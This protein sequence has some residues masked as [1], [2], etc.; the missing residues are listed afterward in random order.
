MAAA[1]CQLQQQTVLWEGALELPRYGEGTA[2]ARFAQPVLVTGVRATAGS[3]D[4]GLQLPQLV[5][6]H[7]RDLHTPT[8][9]RFDL[10]FNAV[11]VPQREMQEWRVDQVGCHRPSHQ[12]AH[13]SILIWPRNSKAASPAA[14]HQQ[15]A[16]VMWPQLA[17]VLMR[18][19]SAVNVQV[20]PTQ[21]VWLRGRCRSIT[22][23]LLGFALDDAPQQIKVGAL[24]WG[25]HSAD[26]F[27]C[28]GSVLACGG[29][30][31]T[32]VVLTA[33]VPCPAGSG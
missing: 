21:H 15:A 28:W 11:A 7:A 13:M 22:V 23:Q 24:C 19:I 17:R 14:A 32:V 10:L 30:A 9:A 20:F 29:A 25:L 31:V 27:T 33:A 26:A 2:E 8:A 3:L 1:A 18:P 6:G 16:L 12:G 5:K 4:G